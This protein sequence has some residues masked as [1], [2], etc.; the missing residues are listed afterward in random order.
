MRLSDDGTLFVGGSNRGWASRGGKPF[1]F[2]RVRWTGKTPFEILEM[3]AKPDGFELSFTEAVDPKTIKPESF[4]MTAW[5]YI[6]QSKY[7]SPE[8]DQATPVI[9][10]ATASADG[11]SVRLVIEGL[12]KGHVHHLT[13]S[14][15]RSASGNQLWHQDAYYTLN[16]IPD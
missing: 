11:K 15:V 1:T 16:E 8:V 4:S 7:G 13:S 10:S 5:T 12:V 2:E 3:R 9:K 6:Y 14:G